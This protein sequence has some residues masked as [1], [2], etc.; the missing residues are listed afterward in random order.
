MCAHWDMIWC[1]RY[2]ER[3]TETGSNRWCMHDISR[4][5]KSQSRKRQRT[6]ERALLWNVKQHDAV[7][8]FVESLAEEAVISDNWYNNVLFQQPEHAFIADL[9][10]SKDRFWEVCQCFCACVACL[11][12]VH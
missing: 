10:M 2:N 9:R 12:S 11:L 5:R 8:T 3:T 6:C 1:C 7:L 4:G